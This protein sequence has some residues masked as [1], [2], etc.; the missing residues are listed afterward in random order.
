MLRRAGYYYQNWNMLYEKWKTKVTTEINYLKSLEIEDLPKM[1]D[2]A[3]VL[4]AEGTSSAYRLMESY[5]QTINSVFKIWQYHFEFLNLGYAAYLNFSMFL[6]KLFPDISDQTITKMVA[7]IDVILFRPDK[8]LRRLAKLAI[9]LEVDNIIMKDDTPEKIMAHLQK[10]PKGKEWCASLESIK[11][12]WFYYNS[13]TGFAHS[14]RSWIDDMRVPFSALRG[15]IKKLK[16]GENIDI[17]TQQ[18]IEQRDAI[19]KKYL[20]LI[21]NEDERTVFLEQLQLCRTVFPYVEEHNFYVEHWH[22]TIFWSKMWKFGEILEKNKFIKDKEDIFFI[23]RYEIS[24]TLYDLCD[25]WATGTPPRGP[26][27]WPKIISKRKEIFN[28]FVRNRPLPALGKPPVQI[29]EP[30]TIMLWGVISDKIINWL[31]SYHSNKN[32]QTPNDKNKGR[33]GNHGLVLKGTA[34]SSGLVEGRA[35]VIFSVDEIKQI[36][37]NE[38]LVCPITAPSWAPMFKQLKGLVAD[39]GGMMSHAAI[40][41]REYSLPAVVGTGL[42]TQLIKTGQLIRVDGS[43]GIVTI[44]D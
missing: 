8:E 14:P 26:S 28:I 27:Y 2:E 1:E 39:V 38:I 31:E 11:D 36:Q 34:A 17:L 19:T 10:D 40:V 37:E 18:I 16:K 43:T 25:S 20:D 24:E 42:A 21:K 33:D 41:C 29:T 44:L 22:H 4:S 12:P 6:K 15:Y 35:R 23:N 3:R 5:D 30:F 9:S 32:N 7:G 13:G